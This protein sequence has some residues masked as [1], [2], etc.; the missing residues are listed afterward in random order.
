[1]DLIVEAR[2]QGRGVVVDVG[3]EIDL[4]TAPALWERLTGVINEGHDLIVLDLAHVGFMDSTGLGTLVGALKR[5]KERGGDLALVGVG[6]PV[7][8]LLSITGLDRV[9]STYGTVEEALS[10]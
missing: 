1:M 2:P 8:R 3:G 5:V 7:M 4:S 6:R 9:F 10:E